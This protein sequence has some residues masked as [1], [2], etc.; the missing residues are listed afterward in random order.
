MRTAFCL[1]FL[2]LCALQPA[3]ASVTG[4]SGWACRGTLRV[5]M[6]TLPDATDSLD[7]YDWQLG[8]IDGW[9]AG[10]YRVDGQDGWA[11]TEGFY[12]GD[13]RAKL[14]PGQTKTWM[15]YIWAVPG[16]SAQDF[17]SSW[18]WA[19]APRDSSVEA[20]LELIQKPSSVTGGP[21]P[22][23][24]WTTPPASLSLPFYGTS[25]GLT[26]YGFKF[27]LTAVP[28]PSSLPALAGG[29]A[30]LGGLALRRKRR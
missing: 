11:G 29:I 17:V 4:V 6:Y 27:T 25:D 28:E 22:G 9:L 1:L 30:G 26:G 2:A 12:N 23:T 21:A 16:G 10:S 7:S 18:T 19:V 20:R 15:L 24:V 13:V 8:P 14:L 3:L 5:A